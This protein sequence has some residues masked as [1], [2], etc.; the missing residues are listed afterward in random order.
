[1]AY[2]LRGCGVVLKSD[3]QKRNAAARKVGRRPVPPVVSSLFIHSRAS[4]VSGLGARNELGDYERDPYL[5]TFLG[6][7]DK[8]TN[9]RIALLQTM[10]KKESTEVAEKDAE[11]GLN[12]TIANNWKQAV[13]KEILDANDF[14]SKYR[15]NKFWDAQQR[16]PVQQPVQDVDTDRIWKQGGGSHEA[17]MLVFRG[18]TATD[19]R[20]LSY[21][22][23]AEVTPSFS[24]SSFA[25]PLPCPALTYLVPLPGARQAVQRAGTHSVSGQRACCAM[26]YPA[27]ACARSQLFLSHQP[28]LTLR[29][30]LACDTALQR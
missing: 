15:A 26:S 9:V 14:Q 21:A 12:F 30:S 5:D 24:W 1:M 3:V 4:Y 11:L 8:G 16:A 28:R 13:K 29:P 18:A 22:A 17:P 19:R 7:M 25:F 2:A 20:E 6:P 27:M 10:K 23:N